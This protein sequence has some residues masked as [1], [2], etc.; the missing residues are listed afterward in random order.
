M[1]HSNMSAD[2]CPSSFGMLPLSWLLLSH[3]NVTADSCPSSFGMLPLS[4]FLWSL[5]SLSAESC[6]SSFGMLPLSWL[7][8][9]CRS[10][11]ADSCPSS[12]GM[13]PLSWLSWS[14]SFVTLP[15]SKDTPF[16]EKGFS[17]TGQ[18]FASTSLRARH[19]RRTLTSPSCG[20]IPPSV[21]VFTF[22]FGGV[23]DGVVDGCAGCSP[24]SLYSPR[25][26]KEDN[27]ALLRAD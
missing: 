12:F 2:S 25:W 23:G 14:H 21:R 18:S 13:L 10:V 4:W 22:G 5:K 8:L 3:S 19:E 7:S 27:I 24:G 6:P 9:S 1:S 16:Q 15:P 17:S 20:L 11:S 26:D